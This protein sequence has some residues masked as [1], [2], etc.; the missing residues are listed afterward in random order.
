MPGRKLKLFLAHSSERELLVNE[1]VAELREQVEK[2]KLDLTVEPWTE[3]R[4]NP[5]IILE[6][7]KDH[8]QGNGEVAVTDFFAV[9]LTPDDFRRSRDGKEGHVPRDNCI[10]E[11][12]MFYSGMEFDK[13]RCFLLSAVPHIHLPSDLGGWKLIEFKAPPVTCSPDDNK[14]A[15][16]K[17]AREIRDQIYNLREYTLPAKSGGVKTITS[18]ELA[19]L[20]QPVEENGHLVECAEVLVNRSQPVELSQREFA[21]QVVANIQAGISYRYFFHDLTA[22][23]MIARLLFRVA[24]DSFDENKQLKKDPRPSKEISEF[25]HT[26]LMEQFNISFL[27]TPGPIEYCIHNA[28]SPDG[29]ACYLRLPFQSQFVTWCK[30]ADA[31]RIATEPKEQDEPCDPIRI[32]RPTKRFD[33]NKE[34]GEQARLWAALKKQFFKLPDDELQRALSVACFGVVLD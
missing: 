28:N 14:E 30:N 4:S 16:R 10:F 5:N 7:L 18:W 2:Y 26:R 1:F 15:V 9:F 27:P 19:R 11:M 17:I 29:A 24:T 31:V 12:G 20:E 34:P 21:A 25:L 8:I 23:P 6:N 22:Y 13:R 33:I 32:F 3:G